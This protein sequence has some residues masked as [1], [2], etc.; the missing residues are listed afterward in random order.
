[1]HGCR[2][3][4]LP[5]QAQ[6]KAHEYPEDTPLE[7]G[8]EDDQIEKLVDLESNTQKA[9]EQFFHSQKLMKH[10]LVNKM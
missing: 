5:I 9:G 7:Q 4:R 6:N 1:M 3:L 10:Y 2:K 8:A